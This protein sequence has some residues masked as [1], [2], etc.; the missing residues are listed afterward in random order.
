MARCWNYQTVFKITLINILKDLLEKGN[1]TFELMRY[2]YT[3]LIYPSHGSENQDV[4][5]QK[6]SMYGL[7]SSQTQQ[8]K[9]SGIL[10]S[11]QQKLFKLTH[12]EENRVKKVEQSILD[13]QD[14]DWATICAL[15]YQKEN[16][17]RT[18]QK[19]YLKRQWLR[20]SQ[21]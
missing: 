11:E 1:N 10:K 12:K 5:N 14:I 9:G 16:R 6:N 21:H 13:L 17:M 4:R 2:T 8:R 20:I 7:K 18:G 15:E 19:K 3:L